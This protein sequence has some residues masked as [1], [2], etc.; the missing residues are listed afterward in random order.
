MKIDYCF[1]THTYR[2]GHAFGEDASFVQAA[3]AQG[4]KELGF[5]D[6]VF[7]PGRPQ[8]GIR[9]DY[10]LLG[11]YI[12]SINSLK[13]KYAKEIN[14]HLG[15]ECEYFPEYVEYY[16][17][18]KSKHHIE[19]LILGQHC[20]YDKEGFHWYLYENCPYERI[21]RYT[22]DLIKGMET[23]LFSYVAHPDIF[24]T[25]FRTFT[26]GCEECARRICKAAE[27]LHIPLEIN[28]GMTVAVLFNDYNGLTYP[29]EDFWRIASEYKIEV[30]VGAD[31][32]RPE[33]FRTVD[34]ERALNLIEKHHLKL[35]TRLKK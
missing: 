9:G 15:F 1:H 27:R 22:D 2:C 12:N 17:E 10:Q 3:L 31:A 29:N 4:M 14:I 16:R 7:L 21:K 32:H 8:P 34:Y 20:F 28:L 26:M 25:P 5:S 13:K 35:L 6:H 19:Y 11:D 23:G 18:L 24:V 30:Y 33:Y